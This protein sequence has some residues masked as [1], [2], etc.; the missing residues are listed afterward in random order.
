MEKL[1]Q[2]QQG[3]DPASTSGKEHPC[4]CCERVFPTAERLAVHVKVHRDGPR[5]PLKC[6]ECCRRF[7]RIDKLRAHQVVHRVGKPH[8]CELCGKAF[9]HKQTLTGHLLRHKGVRQHQC[10]LCPQSF[11]FHVDLTSHQRRHTG[12]RPFKCRVCHR[13]FVDHAD[14]L[15]HER[16]Y[17]GDRPYHC[18][19]CQRRFGRNSV[20]ERHLMCHTGERPYQCH[21]CP[22]TFT[23]S[24]LLQDHLKDHPQ[25]QHCLS[26]LSMHTKMRGKPRQRKITAAA[27]VSMSA[28]PGG[29]PSSA[30]PFPTQTV[31]A[32]STSS[33]PGKKLDTAH[34]SSVRE[35]AAASTLS[36]IPKEVPHLAPSP[37]HN[38]SAPKVKQASK[39]KAKGK[40]KGKAKDQAKPV[41]SP[42]SSSSLLGYCTLSEAELG[43][44][45]VPPLSSSVNQNLHLQKHV[46]ERKPGNLRNVRA[47]QQQ[48]NM[49]ASG[50][51]SAVVISATP[52][53]PSSSSPRP[54]ADVAEVKQASRV[55]YM[56]RPATFMVSPLSPETQTANL[57]ARAQP[58]MYPPGSYRILP[59]HGDLYGASGHGLVV[60]SFTDH[61][62]LVSNNACKVLSQPALEGAAFLLPHDAVPGGGHGVSEVEPQAGLSRPLWGDQDLQ[63]TDN[64]C[65]AEL[66]EELNLMN[67]LSACPV[68]PEDIGRH[69]RPLSPLCSICHMK[70]RGWLHRS[71]GK[72]RRRQWGV[73][74]SSGAPPLGSHRRWQLLQCNFCPFV[75]RFES[76]IR[77]HQLRHTKE[78]P[79]RCEF[80]PKSFQRRYQLTQH[81]TIRHG[82]KPLPVPRQKMQ[83]FS[84]HMASLDPADN[85]SQFQVDMGADLFPF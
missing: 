83:D 74:G 24:Y 32:A 54:T 1:Q 36:A 62:S 70:P 57:V 69:S 10:D 20:L 56:H 43:Y 65:I 44:A 79:H 31:V 51:S 67:S 78:R 29:Q 50:T 7:T 80:C 27:A 49:V 71:V 82:T 30:S 53:V 9:T 13:C 63:Q 11:Y 40:A 41:C 46:Y 5:R 35:A 55:D 39:C 59:P 73:L 48:K 22:N 68:V 77:R 76:A 42:V 6:K 37:L 66:K 25:P 28:V 58:M 85:S 33:V 18:P 64:Q 38:A 84:G 3:N 12:E 2:Q 21:L 47:N 75:S 60:S 23:R 34:V 16:L 45:F 81:M 14:Q 61:S 26:S 52:N 8:Q 17:S 72:A 19:I 4:S 15:R